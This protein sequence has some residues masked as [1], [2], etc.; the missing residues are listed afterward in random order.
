M[1]AVALALIVAAD[2][3]SLGLVDGGVPPLPADWS[4]F[5]QGQTS[6]S[7]VNESLLK[8][9]ANTTRELKVQ[10][11]GDALTVTWNGTVATTT[12]PKLAARTSAGRQLALVCKAVT[13][14]VHSADLTFTPPKDECSGADERPRSKSPKTLRVQLCRVMIDGSTDDEREL[15]LVPGR[16]LER[17]AVDADC[18]QRHAMRFLP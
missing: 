10:R 4:L 1:I 13:Q 16:A 18:T 6:V 15:P 12:D 8:R 5:P 9:N 11:R 2:P 7:D 14:V 3:P 17:L